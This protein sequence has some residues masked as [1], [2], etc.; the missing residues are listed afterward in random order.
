MNTPVNSTPV[1]SQEYSQIEI[2]LSGEEF[3]LSPY[4]MFDLLVAVETAYEK[5]PSWKALLK[6]I[7]LAI[8]NSGYTRETLK[9]S[10]INEMSDQLN[11]FKI[12]AEE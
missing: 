4:Y 7:N 6:R 9:E 8:H 11:K 10:A 1:N 5:D 2:S 12:I 3:I